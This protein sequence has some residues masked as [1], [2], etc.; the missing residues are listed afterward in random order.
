MSGFKAL[1]IVILS[2]ALV[3]ALL[4]TWLDRYR[5]TRWREPLFVAIY[6]IAADGSPRT[7][8]YLST[9]TAEAFKPIDRFFSEEAA[10]YRLRTG[11]PV[12]TRLHSELSRLPP[13]HDPGAGMIATAVWSLRLRVWAWQVTHGSHD[14]QDVR[15]FVLYHDPSLMATMPHS[16]GLAKGLI[17]VVYAFATPLMDGANDVVIAH[18]LLHTVGA[19]D[20]YDPHDDRPRFPEGFADP[21]Q[22]PLYPQQ[23]AELMA[24]RRM[25]A[26]DRWQQPANL[27]ETAVG[28]ATALEIHWSAYGR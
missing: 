28:G 12:R 19:T 1:R 15:I 18:E 11:E 14:P 24:G 9:L 21:Q 8:R 10:H 25:L 3:L 13:G 27:G 26:A 16:L 4:S 7:H 2:S 22:I 17:G 6:P 20:K 23:K 5:S